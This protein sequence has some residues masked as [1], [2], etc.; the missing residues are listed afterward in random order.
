MT[1][2]GDRVWLPGDIK[3]VAGAAQDARFS[4]ERRVIS[5]KVCVDCDAIGWGQY[6]DE[7]HHSPSQWGLLGT[8]A[9]YQI[10]ARGQLEGGPVPE[11]AQVRLLLPADVTDIGALHAAVQTKAAPPKC[12][13]HN[14]I[15]LAFIAEA[16]AADKPGDI[17]H[18]PHPPLV[19][20]IFSLARQGRSWNPRSAQPGGRDYDGHAVT[21]A[22]V[23]HALR[24]YEDDNPEDVRAALARCQDELLAWRRRE[25]TLVINRPLFE[26]YQLG[27]TTDYLIFNPELMTALFFLRIGNPRPAR[28]FVASVTRE[29][30]RNVQ[31]NNGFEG[32]LGMIPLVDQEWASRL[33]QLFVGTYT[34]KTRRHLLLPGRLTTPV[35]RWALFIGC[36][37]V[38]VGTLMA[39]GVD[40]KT[41]V[42]VFIAGAVVTGA[43][44][45]LQGRGDDE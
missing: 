32:Q 13:L 35:V 3:A 22:Y 6:L 1:L 38:L 30:N 9:G 15:R 10:L 14:V 41:G 27:S 28:R 39:L 21:T 18:R 34:D 45:I 20:Y 2:F 31:A 24:R 36:V 11:L 8:S 19:D 42:L 4:I 5:G 7:V 25:R 16:L 23:L 12:D 17:I 43:S 26:G 40:F 37:L 33:L 29:L 44:F